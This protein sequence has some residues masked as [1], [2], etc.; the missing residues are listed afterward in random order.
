MNLGGNLTLCEEGQDVKLLS[1]KSSDVE[2]SQSK[3]FRFRGWRCLPVAV[4]AHHCTLGIIK[5]GF[6]DLYSHVLTSWRLET[7]HKHFVLTMIRWMGTEASHSLLDETMIIWLLMFWKS[8]MVANNWL[9][10]PFSVITTW[11][12]QWW[13]NN[14]IV[15]DWINFVVF[16]WEN[17]IRPAC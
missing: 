15:D 4:L 10:H 14:I 9:C 1:S 13:R 11:S 3:R 16:N 7:N 17:W 8:K 2:I 6:H 12:C 5:T